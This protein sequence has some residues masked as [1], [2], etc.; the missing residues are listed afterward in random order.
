MKSLTTIKMSAEPIS[1]SAIRG[2]NYQP[3]YAATGLEIWALKFDASRIEDEIARCKTY[4][5]GTNL[6]RLWLSFD[7]YLHDRNEFAANF[8]AV[9]DIIGR[10]GLQAMPCL[11]NNWHSIPDFGGVAAE[12]IGYWNHPARCHVFT[13]Y[14]DAVV[15]PHGNDPRVRLWDLC[16]E[17][18]NSGRSEVFVPWLKQLY[19][20]C[21]NIG[22]AAPITVG[23]PASVPA[24]ELVEPFCD[25]LTPHCYFAEGLWTKDEAAFCATLDALVGFAE[26]VGKP[27][28]A[29]ETGWGAIDDAHRARLLR[30]ELQALVERNMGFCI[31]MLNHSLV[32]DGHRS[33]FGVVSEACFM[34]CIEADGTLRAGHEAIN[35]F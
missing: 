11:F 33:E 28:F 7:A 14:L 5:P 26:K 20:H 30:V 23:V 24:L 15:G 12:M 6:L 2:F 19:E 25:V 35:H 3:G 10:H 32:A 16:N 21:R 17:P 4:F 18:F 9:L 22:V 13:E 29:G 1:E 31:H 34:G 8:A 27:I